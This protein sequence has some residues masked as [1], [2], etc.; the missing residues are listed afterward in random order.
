MQGATTVHFQ[1]FDADV[2]RTVTVPNVAANVEQARLTQSSKEEKADQTIRRTTSSL[3][4]DP[5]IH[6]FAG[7][8][9]EVS[10]LLSVTGSGYGSDCSAEEELTLASIGQIERRLS[11]PNGQMERR[12][13]RD[14]Q[15]PL[16]RKRSSNSRAF[17]RALY[18]GPEGGYDIILMSETVYS[19]K[20]LPKLYT[21]VKQVRRTEQ[22]DGI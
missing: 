19:L 18:D 12:N 5:N 21:L 15:P 11:A 16:P 1:D 4:Q 9:G 6:Y 7:D 22:T 13:S 20:T 3:V 14:G 2:L 8:W 10:S 17:E